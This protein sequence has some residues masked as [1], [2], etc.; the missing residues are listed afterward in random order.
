MQSIWYA[1]YGSN[2]LEER[3]LCYI[4]GGRPEGASR[5]YAGC[6]DKS[7]P[8]ENKSLELPFKLYFAKKAS[9]WNQGGVAF[10][11]KE[12]APEEKTLGR[13]YRITPAQFVDVVR[14]EN[15]FE[16]D[17][18]IDFDRALQEGEL[19]IRE[20][21]WYGQL[22]FVGKEKGAPIFTFTH[23]EAIAPIVRPD[24]AY[25]RTIIRGIQETYGWP[26]HQIVDYLISKE[27]VAGNYT[28]K[29]LADLV[30]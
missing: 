19:L 15:A 2:L 14:Q 28:E 18:T 26:D 9:V 3:F 30:A 23:Q 12:K 17:L 24:E 25:L 5:T 21:A 4:R 13:M 1:S 20:G 22:L 7:L 10:I 11:H 27:G 6:V 8:L 16:E 29:S